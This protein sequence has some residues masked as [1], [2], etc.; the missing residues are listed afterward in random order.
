MIKR[1][2]DS[3]E[4]ITRINN[5]RMAAFDAWMDILLNKTND[6]A[7]RLQAAQS[8]KTWADEEEKL[9]DVLS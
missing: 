5:A 2:I 4:S 6:A 9:L 8:L 3:N 1:K 7:V